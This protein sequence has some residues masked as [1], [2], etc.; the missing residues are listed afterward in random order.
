[1]NDSDNEND[2]GASAFN[3]GHSSFSVQQPLRLAL[4]LHF[5]LETTKAWSTKG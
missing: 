5:S 4:P 3:K 1:M 2:I